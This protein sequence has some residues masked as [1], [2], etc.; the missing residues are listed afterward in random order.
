M[1]IQKLSIFV[2]FGGENLWKGVRQRSLISTF[3]V[4][5]GSGDGGGGGDINK[6]G[7]NL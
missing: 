1:I 5:F 6:N 7:R 2:A 4:T 3:P